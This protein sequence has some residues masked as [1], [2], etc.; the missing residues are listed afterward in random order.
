[1][2]AMPDNQSYQTGENGESSERKAKKKYDL[3]K[4]KE[5]FLDNIFP[6]IMVVLIVVIIAGSFY[7]L[8]RLNN[9]TVN[10]MVD[11]NVA[12]FPTTQTTSEPTAFAPTGTGLFAGA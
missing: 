1:M 4:A 11:Q 8:L 12:P 5:K 3:S 10:E 2:S 9:D 7:L 6:L